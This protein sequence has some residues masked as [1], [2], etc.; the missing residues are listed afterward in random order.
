MQKILIVIFVLALSAAAQTSQPV[1][2]QASAKPAAAKSDNL[3]WEKMRTLVGKWDGRF[4]G[5]HAPISYEL[6][7]GGS[8]L[9][10]TNGAQ[11]D[12]M[13]TM[14][15]PDGT[16]MMATHYCG[17]G[18]QPRMRAKSITNNS[19]AFDFVDV[20]NTKSKSDDVMRSL[21]IRFIDKDHVEQE[22]TSEKD[23]KQSTMVFK[24]ERKKS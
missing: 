16:G 2:A 1:A 4:E 22:W 17:A 24:L 11:N 9:M 12:S 7:G 10:E 20:T 13:I 8:A 18:N 15:H 14:F 5:M 19:I 21:V 23:G 3:L 6:T